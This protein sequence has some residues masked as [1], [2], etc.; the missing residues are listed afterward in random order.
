MR[1]L[2]TY[3][4][5]IILQNKWLQTQNKHGILINIYREKYRYTYIHIGAHGIER[6]RGSSQV[7]M[8]AFEIG[9]DSRREPTILISKSVQCSFA[10]QTAGEGMTYLIQRAH[11]RRT[12]L[13]E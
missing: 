9:S 3:E 8:H 12:S 10:H 5:Y 11:R 7:D 2:R 4:W 6:T 1:V 13:T